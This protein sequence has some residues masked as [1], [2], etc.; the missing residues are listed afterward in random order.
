MEI[1]LNEQIAHLR[2]ESGM[3]QEALAQKLGVTNQAVS[4]WE[5]GVCCPD[6]SLLP[7][8][9]DIFGVSIDALMGRRA[10]AAV[11]TVP[12]LRNTIDVLPHG[13]DFSY[14]RRL[15]YVLHAVIF[16][17][18]MT[19]PGTGNPGWNTDDAVL[20][21]GDAEWGYSC[22]SVPEITTVL[23]RG[24]VLFSDN[25]NFGLRDDRIGAVARILACFAKPHNL[26]C[27]M[28]LY[29]M[30]VADEERHIPASA[31]AAACGM[32]EAVVTDAFEGDMAPFLSEKFEGGA[33]V[34]R[35]KGQHMSILPILSLLSVG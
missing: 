1:R 32:P 34:Y 31:V 20:H 8:I 4:K 18:C 21:A 28:S 29:D 25:L 12:F 6:L 13:E 10:E 33:A 9:A 19:A 17:K 26:R 2:R 16:S 5:A 22:V 23:R 24:T 35:I 7:E 14:T 15:A 30:T 11:D 3:T 27:A